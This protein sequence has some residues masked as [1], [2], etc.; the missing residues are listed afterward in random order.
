MVERHSG[1]ILFLQSEKNYKNYI[2]IDVKYTKVKTYQSIKHNSQHN[3]NNSI[4]ATANSITAT[5]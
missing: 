4:T 2:G 1:K 5:A 3:I